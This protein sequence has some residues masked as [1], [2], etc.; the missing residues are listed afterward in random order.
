[1]RNNKTEVEK[2]R[3]CE[4]KKR[5]IRTSKRGWMPLLLLL[6]AVS[7]F[8]CS[9]SE[10]RIYVNPEADMTYYEKVAIIPFGNLSSERS[11]GEKVTEAFMT[12]LLIAQK[13]QITDPGDVY[14]TVSAITQSGSI[15]GIL[16][17]QDHLM[18]ISNELGVQGIIEGVVHT[19]EMARIGQ[20]QYPLIS[21]TVRLIDAQKGTIVWQ[22]SY[23]RQGGPTVPI[24][25]IGE[26][27]TLGKLTQ[28]ATRELVDRFVKEALKD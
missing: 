12:E 19:L 24:L 26:T 10:H 15:G 2:M 17:K 25:N 18:K 5:D 22:S 27:Y 1:M 23:T 11:A 6:L 3:S 9:L 16:L 4:D 8:S 14:H 7:A 20:E 28:Q 13:I 21:L